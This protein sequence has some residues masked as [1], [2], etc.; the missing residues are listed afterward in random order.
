M[1]QKEWGLAYVAFPRRIVGENGRC[2]ACKVES[3]FARRLQPYLCRLV[4]AVSVL[5]PHQ[6][7]LALSITE[8][9]GMELSGWHTRG[10]RSW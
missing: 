7:R 4:N 10:P 9:R 1:L 3:V 2:G 5:F 8:E 6:V